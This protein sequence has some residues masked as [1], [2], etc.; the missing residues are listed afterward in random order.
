MSVGDPDSGHLHHQQPLSHDS[1]SG[2][3]QIKCHLQ[4]GADCYWNH[5]GNVYFK[6]LQS[7]LLLV[8]RSNFPLHMLVEILIRYPFKKD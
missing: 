5:F 4:K 2:E 7:V 3:D 8:Q 6:D 1:N